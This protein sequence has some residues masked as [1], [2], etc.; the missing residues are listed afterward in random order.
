MEYFLGS[1]IT[2]LTIFFILRPASRRMPKIKVLARYSQSTRFDGIKHVLP[3]LSLV[4]LE[5]ETQSRKA[6]KENLVSIIFI[7]NEAYWIK[8]NSLYTAT[9]INGK[10]DSENAKKVDTMTMDKIQLEKTQFIV[11]KLT[12]GK[13][14]DSGYP[15]KS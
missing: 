7:D 5:K 2:L 14:N 8:D 13:G 6:E 12:E 1:V 11:Q 4:S 9:I 3:L 15:R 10:V